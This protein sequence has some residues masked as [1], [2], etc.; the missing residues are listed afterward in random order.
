MKF[1]PMI[2]IVVYNLLISRKLFEI[3]KK[4]KAMEQRAIERRLERKN[5]VGLLL[6]D[7][8]GLGISFQFIFK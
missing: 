6:N 5:K 7:R 4:R 2:T 8:M 3:A 1:L